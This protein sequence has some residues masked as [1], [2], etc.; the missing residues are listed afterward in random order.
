MFWGTL[1]RY[2][3]SERLQVRLY[4]A[5]RLWGRG[6]ARDSGRGTRRSWWRNFA[7]QET[8]KIFTSDGS[9]ALLHPRDHILVPA[10]VAQMDAQ[11][12]APLA[13]LH[14]LWW[15]ETNMFKDV[16]TA[17]GQHMWTTWGVFLYDV[18]LAFVQ[19]SDS[20]CCILKGHPERDALLLTYS[21]CKYCLS[22]R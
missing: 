11:V 2:G 13:S 5:I 21:I 18:I 19:V 7:A 20:C 6:T 16:R 1:Q 9:S 10:L 14:A 3:F 12:I 22:V 17:K 8:D 4:R 15:D